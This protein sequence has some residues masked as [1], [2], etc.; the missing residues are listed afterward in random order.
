MALMKMR[1]PLRPSLL[2]ACLLLAAATAHAQAA[3]IA[4]LPAQASQGAMVIGHSVPNADVRVSGRKLS[5]DAQGRFVF[6]IGRDEKGPVTVRIQPPGA[7]AQI[8]DIRI[9]PRDWPIQRIN[10]V[11]PATVNPPPAIAQRIARENGRIVAARRDDSA[12]SDFAQAFIWPLKGRISG[13]FGNQRVFNGTP[14]SPH[15][16][17]DIATAQGTPIRAPAG[18]RITL[19][20][21]D[22]YLTGGTVMIDHGHGISSN[23]LHMSRLDVKVGDVVKQGDVVGAVG[24]T[25][26][27][28]GPHL[29][30]GMTWFDTRIDPLLVLDG[31]K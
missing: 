4:N 5:V 27:S 20:E 6:G 11:P 21:K 31:A 19:A 24:S 12:N 7:A 28:T 3:H 13:R 10:G 25:G 15:S 17:M 2:T 23:F 26:R 16:G 9:T 14:K 30:W 1:M 22:F 18:G 29:H 8:A